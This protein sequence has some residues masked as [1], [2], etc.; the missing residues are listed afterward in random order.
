MCGT[1]TVVTSATNISNAQMWTA[2][3]VDSTL[4][5]TLHI[6]TCLGW[7]RVQNVWHA[8]D[9]PQIFTTLYITGKFAISAIYNIIIPS[10]CPSF[11]ATWKCAPY[12]G[13]LAAAGCTWSARGEPGYA[14]KWAGLARRGRWTP[15]SWAQRAVH[16]QWGLSQRACASTVGF[17]TL[18]FNHNRAECDCGL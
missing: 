9:L 7:H 14:G 15:C 17:L 6:N 11:C 2:A 3:I 4:V 10:V 18:Q 1:R 8:S 16:V 5:P 12:M 13:A